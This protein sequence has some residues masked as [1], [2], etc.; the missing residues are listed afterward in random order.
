MI[1]FNLAKSKLDTDCRCVWSQRIDAHVYVLF[2]QVLGNCCL[3]QQLPAKTKLCIL[4][5]NQRKFRNGININ[6]NVMLAIF[7]V[8]MA[9]ARV[10]VLGFQGGTSGLDG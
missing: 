3:Y 5:V 8:K 10:F 4:D 2:V 7:S 1:N 9:G 6:L